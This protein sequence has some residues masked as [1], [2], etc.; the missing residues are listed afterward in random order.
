MTVATNVILQPRLGSTQNEGDSLMLC[1]KANFLGCRWR[2]TDLGSSTVPKLTFKF[3]V[4]LC[5][6][7]QEW[8][9]NKEKNYVYKALTS[10]RGDCRTDGACEGIA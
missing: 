3:D 6:T 10:S 1:W 8:C 5:P 7:L 9:K 2:I 4:G